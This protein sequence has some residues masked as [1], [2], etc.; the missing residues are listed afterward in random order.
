MRDI[1]TK[2]KTNIRFRTSDS[3]EK[4]NTQEVKSTYLF[5]SDDNL[6]FMR[7]DNFEQ[8]EIP[9]LILEDKLKLLNDGMKV[10]L[11]YV[12]EK[13]VNIRLP[14][15]LEIFIESADAV[16]KG[17]TASSSFKPAI[18]DRGLKVL[19]PPHIKQG[20]KVIVHSENLEYVEKS[21]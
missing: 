10:T 18:T 16:V 3:I 4:L 8:V 20:D 15:T 6:T 1:Q 21:K 5:A 13:I 9:K 14:K 12:N 19:V 11:E 17:Q 2:N 7:D